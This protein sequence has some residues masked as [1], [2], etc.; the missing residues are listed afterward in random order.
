MDPNNIW[1]AIGSRWRNSVFQVIVNELVAIPRRPYSQGNDDT[2]NGS[3]FI[4]D[5]ANGLVVT[6]AHVVMNALSISGRLPRFGKRDLGMEVVSVCQQKDLA[7]I[8]VVKD[9]LKL[10]LGGQDPNDLNIPFG[11]S[12][13]LQQGQEVMT[14]GYPM[15]EKEVKYTQGII[16]GFKA[17]MDMEVD[18][19]GGNEED[20]RSRSPTYIQTD[21]ALNE[22]NSG[23]PLLDKQGRCIGIN[24]SGVLF[25]QGVGYAIASRTLLAIL[26]TMK[27]SIVV[28]MPTFGFGWSNSTRELM[29]EKCGLG[30][31]HGVYVRRVDPDSC[32]TGLC[33]GD[34]VTHLCYEDPF[35]ATKRQHDLLLEPNQCASPDRILVCGYFDRFGDLVLYEVDRR[36]L[37]A[38]FGPKPKNPASILSGER[39]L[40]LAEVT[41][42]IP[43]GAHVHLQICRNENDS[44]KW[45]RLDSQYL[46]R[47]S[48]RIPRLLPRFQDVDY[49]VFAGICVV[50]ISLNILE[51]IEQLRRYLRYDQQRFGRCLVITQIFPKNNMSKPPFGEG[52]ILTEVNGIPVATLE[53]LRQVLFGIPPDS[54]QNIIVKSNIGSVFVGSIPKL[55][56]EDHVIVD[57]FGVEPDHAIFSERSSKLQLVQ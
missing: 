17:D 6:N 2:I 20:A 14:I 48:D 47:K 18:Y 16:S 42:M 19:D 23:G 3:G 24:A 31:L 27:S 29:E 36:E 45:Y 13:D 33:I 28:D 51:D 53:E 15:G 46:P 56:E 4:I 40:S 52:E 12:M 43:I 35:W 55:R 34:V 5:A 37:Q 44:S 38:P 41:D 39:R 10:L 32:F 7:L 21:A 26:C 57:N 25:A 49:E 22:G 30:T 1:Q 8:R 11:D 54:N 9:D 50:P